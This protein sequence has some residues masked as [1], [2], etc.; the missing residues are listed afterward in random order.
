M[1]WF[2]GQ[3]ELPTPD[4]GY[5]PS[6]ICSC[7]SLLGTV[8]GP[9]SAPLVLTSPGN[10]SQS[11]VNPI[12]QSRLSGVG[13]SL[14]VPSPHRGPV[15]TDKAG[16]DRSWRWIRIDPTLI[17]LVHTDLQTWFGGAITVLLPQIW[18]WHRESSDAEA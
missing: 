15:D 18:Y 17:Q 7:L 13:P 4:V 10:N 2:F 16:V 9:N 8:V 12:S 6:P 14:W 11:V 5:E 1:G 3:Y